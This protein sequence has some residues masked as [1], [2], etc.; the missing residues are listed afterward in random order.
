MADSDLKKDNIAS[1]LIWFDKFAVPSNADGS[2]DVVTSDHDSVDV[3]IMEALDGWVCL[4]LNQV[5]HDD[6]AKEFG[7]FFQVGSVKLCLN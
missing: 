4:F 5:L 2:E 6:E 7:F 1:Y 3:C